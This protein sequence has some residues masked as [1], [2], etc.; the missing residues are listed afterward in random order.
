MARWAAAPLGLLVLLGVLPPSFVAHA[1]RGRG[2]A[3]V[4]AAGSAPP[5][6]VLFRAT[7]ARCAPPLRLAGGAGGERTR[8]A[9]TRARRKT[10]DMEVDVDHELETAVKRRAQ[11]SRE[12]PRPA[13]G[14]FAP[15]CF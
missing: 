11:V 5:S 14:P 8:E 15:R 6:A 2:T 9:T 1:G 4:R 10:Q 7:A 13:I 3:P 12:P